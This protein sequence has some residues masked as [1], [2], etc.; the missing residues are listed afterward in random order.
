V[1]VTAAEAAVHVTGD[2]DAQPLIEF[3]STYFVAGD[4]AKARECAQKTVLGLRRS[5]PDS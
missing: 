4:K 1:A 3:A 2:K 5:C